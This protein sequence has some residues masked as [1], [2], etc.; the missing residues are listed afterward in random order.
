MLRGLATVNFFADDLTAAQD[1]YTQL[2]S[3]EPYFVR[4]IEGTPAYLEF[5]IGDYQHELGFINS[6]FAS[7]G[8]SHQPGGAIA[9][10]AVDDV[11][12]T[13]E[14]LVSLGASVHQEPVEHGPGFVTASVVDPL[15]SARRDVQPALRGRS[16]V[17]GESLTLHGHL[18]RLCSPVA[19]KGTCGPVAIAGRGP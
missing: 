16:R 14:R 15:G 5:R 11:H 7:P 17:R 13:F 19:K 12:A 18:E 9:S 8:R 6:R 2:L 4:T 3:V 10:W 1:W